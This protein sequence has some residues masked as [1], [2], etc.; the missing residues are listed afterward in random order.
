M[1]GE[2]AY[3]CLQQGQGRFPR[4][5]AKDLAIVAELEEQYTLLVS[6]LCMGVEQLCLDGSSLSKQACNNLQKLQGQQI[7]VIAHLASC[8]LPVL[9]KPLV[10]EVLDF[11]G[12][13][14]EKMCCAMFPKPASSCFIRLVRSLMAWGSHRP[15]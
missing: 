7:D 11:S 3:K 9:S 12:F 10:S 6:A 8:V 4:A 14:F 1:G 5:V 2:G 15:P 13:D